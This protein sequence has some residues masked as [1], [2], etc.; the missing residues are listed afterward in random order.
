MK[1]FIKTYSE[2]VTISNLLLA[3]EEF[4]AGK[5]K[6][7]DVAIFQGRLIDNIFGLYYDLKEKNYRHDAYQAFK[8][9]DPKPR[10]I[11]KAVVRDRLLHHLLYQ[12]TYQYFDRQFVYDSYSC[13]LDKGT[14]RA[15][16]RLAEL[17]D[18]V[19]ENNRKAV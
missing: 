16:R 3:W 17:R 2:I 11:H 15:V 13:R 10:N 19:S 1:K 6:R 9:S 8:I 18:K 5:K 12:E 14:H 4:L 7:A